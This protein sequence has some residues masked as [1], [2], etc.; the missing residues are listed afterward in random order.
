M[1]PAQ[2]QAQVLQKALRRP[3]LHLHPC[4]YVGIHV[5]LDIA[6]TVIQDF[7]LK[8]RQTRVGIRAEILQQYLILLACEIRKT[9]WP[10][11]RRRLLGLDSRGTTRLRFPQARMAES[12]TWTTANCPFEPDAVAFALEVK[13]ATGQTGWPR[14]VA[15]LPAGTASPAPRSRSGNARFGR[16]GLWG[17]RHV[18]R[19][20]ASG[21][22]G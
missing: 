3:S 11:H 20:V 5:D 16:P 9:D 2:S 12:D 6:L 17:R 15:L 7:S 8:G 18:V 19:G 21:G 14:L 4:Q 1:D 10:C 22:C 13:R